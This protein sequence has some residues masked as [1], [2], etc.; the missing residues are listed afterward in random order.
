VLYNAA[1]DIGPSPKWNRLR[2]N[3]RN[4]SWCEAYAII[5]CSQ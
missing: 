3:L 4:S 1:T 5:M 2:N